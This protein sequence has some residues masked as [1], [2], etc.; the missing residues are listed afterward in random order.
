MR[1]SQ[2]KAFKSRQSD[3]NKAVSSQ[4][5]QIKMDLLLERAFKKGI[6]Q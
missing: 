1:K 3:I 6:K 2:Y 4:R 5:G